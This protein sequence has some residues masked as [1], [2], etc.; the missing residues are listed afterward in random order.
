MQRFDP[1]WRVQ[2]VGHIGRHE[3][4]L[5]ALGIDYPPSDDK[6]AFAVENLRVGV[7]RGGVLVKPLSGFEREEGDRANWFLHQLAAYY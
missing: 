5:T 1:L 3:N 2:G 4:K 7:V 6:F